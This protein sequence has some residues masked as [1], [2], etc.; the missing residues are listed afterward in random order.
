M[1]LIA[2]ICEHPD[3]CHR[4]KDFRFYILKD[5]TKTKHYRK[6]CKPHCNRLSRTKTLGSVDIAHKS[7]GGDGHINSLGYRIHY[8][9]DHPLADSNGRVFEHRMVLYEKIGLGIHLC[10]WCEDPLEW[11]VNL[12]VDHVNFKKL[13]NRVENL[14]PSCQSCNT[15]RF[16][17]LIRY[18]LDNNIIT[19]E[20]LR[21]L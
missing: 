21:C 12:N 20:V 11:G 18:I 16:N 1:A 5:G 7:K 6:Y 8:K 14:V 2:Q 3:G 15:L 17:R 13:D 4:K 9:P 19:E 10:H